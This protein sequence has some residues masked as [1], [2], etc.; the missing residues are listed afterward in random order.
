MYPLKLK[1]RLVIA[2]QFNFCFNFVKFCCRIR[3]L[4][5][6]RKLFLKAQ[7]HLQ[8]ELEVTKL[9]KSLRTV[10][11]IQRVLFSKYQS[12][13]LPYLNSNV[14]DLSIP[15]PPNTAHSDVQDL[16]S[17]YLMSLLNPNTQTKIDK[18]ILKS[19]QPIDIHK[20]RQSQLKS[21]TEN[22]VMT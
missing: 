9:V 4:K 18:R 5:D 10:D 20:R 3:N 11:M 17:V 14:I 13:F 1:K 16:H 19:L 22:A 7:E 2:I 6:Q 15:D 12:H 8:N 21:V